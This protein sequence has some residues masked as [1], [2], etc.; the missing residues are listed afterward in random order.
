MTI[1]TGLK[2][3]PEKVE[4]QA[5]A[6]PTPEKKEP[7][8][9]VKEVETETQPKPGTEG[10]LPGGA[11]ERTREQFDKLKSSNQ[12][13]LEANKL[14][15]GE[16][17]RRVQS[18]QTFAPIQ[19]IPGV[20]QAPTQAP[21]QTPT[22]PAQVPAPDVEQFVAVDPITGERYL[23][24]PK[25]GQAIADANARAKR[26]EKSVQNYIL[27]QRSIEEEQQTREAFTA[28]PELNP[29][30]KKFEKGLHTRTRALLLD[31]MMN[32][33]DY[34]NHSLSF[35]EAGDLAKKQSAKDAKELTKKVDEESQKAL[36][37]KEQASLAVEGKPGTPSP[38]QEPSEELAN[39]AKKTREGD[40]WALARRLQNTP[41]TGTP[42][43]STEEGTEEKK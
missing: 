43:S 30:S 14:L 6:K 32:P 31:S 29:K 7:V 2:R 41:H 18:E 21:L 12:R 16:I 22:Q 37:A 27:Q 20:P 15:Q 40:I 34:D 36:E 5:G 1:N 10:E 38:S 19:Q 39:L 23:N 3:P 13:L 24:E 33:S 26:A 4:P 35:K 17:A 11:S 28:H 8:P 25:L 42:T 9:Q